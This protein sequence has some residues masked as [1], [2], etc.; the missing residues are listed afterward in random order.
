MLRR[1]ISSQ[2]TA[3]AEAKLAR[4]GSYQLGGVASVIANARQRHLPHGGDGKSPPPP[5]KHE[6]PDVI[7][8]FLHAALHSLRWERAFWRKALVQSVARECVVGPSHG[9]F[10]G[11]SSTAAPTAPLPRPLPRPRFHSRCHGPFQG[12]SRGPA[13][14]APLPQPRFHCGPLQ[15]P[16]HSF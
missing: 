12:P 5:P 3:A 15:Y 16:S 11:P 14:T 8:G 4:K 6:D 9:P 13:S 7:G 1:A 2:A 10:H